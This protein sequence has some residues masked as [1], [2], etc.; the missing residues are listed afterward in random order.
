ME[1]A[2]FDRFRVRVSAGWQLDAFL[3]IHGQSGAWLTPFADAWRERMSLVAR[4][5]S[6]FD[7]TY[8]LVGSDNGEQIAVALCEPAAIDSAGSVDW[9]GSLLPGARPSAETSSCA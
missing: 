9:S 5:T 2:A 6:V 7:G 8:A 1:P 3:L 4:Q